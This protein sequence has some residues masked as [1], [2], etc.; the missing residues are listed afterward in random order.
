MMTDGTFSDGR[1][2]GL[3]SKQTSQGTGVNMTGGLLLRTEVTDCYAYST[4]GS[5]AGPGG[6]Y[7]TGGVVQDC[8][9]PR[10]EVDNST[11]IGGHGAGLKITDGLV[12]NTLVAWNRE[13]YRTSGVA[14]TGGTLVDCTIVSNL[15]DSA[16]QWGGVYNDGADFIRCTIAANRS[17]GGA[18]CYNV[19]KGYAGTFTDCTIG[20]ESHPG[21]PT[22]TS[23]STVEALNAAVAGACDGSVI[24]LE[25]GTYLLENTLYLTNAVTL[26]GQGD[27][28]VTATKNVRPFFLRNPQAMLKNLTI[29]DC[30]QPAVTI[31]DGG[32]V[33]GCCFRA[34]HAAQA[35]SALHLWVS[36]TVA[37]SSFVDNGNNAD[38]GRDIDGGAV[39]YEGRSGVFDR[40]LFVSNYISAAKLDNSRFRRGSAMNVQGVVRLRSCLFARNYFNNSHGGGTI[41][42]EN[43]DKWTRDSE[44]SQME[45]CTIVDNSTAAARTFDEFVDDVVAGVALNDSARVTGV[46]CIIDGNVD[47]AG[48]VS[49]VFV[50]SGTVF[51][52]TYSQV[53]AGSSVIG[54]EGNISDD[55]QFKD[56]AAN[57]YKLSSGSPCVDA[58]TNDTWMATAVDLARKPRL[59][60][61]RVDMGAYERQNV[62]LMLLVR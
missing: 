44:Y 10:N 17:F 42:F 48:S 29:A 1:I 11:H 40:C 2:T 62:G 49:N 16:E 14:A 26:V 45:N 5:S 7:M 47:Y 31:L 43:T 39:R 50:R 3:Y 36:G 25:A 61:K 27:V 38:A 32:T 8:K 52:L 30:K 51:N 41:T 19:R 13:V 33:T 37:E 58:G 4:G 57:C 23:V 15:V 9:I 20:D 46:N 21:T 60:G 54:G 22:I 56:R 55:P 12:T 28:K 59:S 35:G 53:D 6:V 34:N 24:T 18:V